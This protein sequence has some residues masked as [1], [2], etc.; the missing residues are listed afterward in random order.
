MSYPLASTRL[1]DRRIPLFTTIHTWRIVAQSWRFFESL[2]HPYT[3]VNPVSRKPPT[4]ASRHPLN[5]A[6]WSR[7]HAQSSKVGQAYSLTFCRSRGQPRTRAP[8][9]SISL[10]AAL[11]PPIEAP[12]SRRNERSYP[13]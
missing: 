10:L 9:A 5:G 7:N 3:G 2:K 6:Q 4:A 13:R 8:C 1:V 11:I 12:P